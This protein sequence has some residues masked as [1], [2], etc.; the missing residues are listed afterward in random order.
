MRRS[1]SR[2]GVELGL[3]DGDHNEYQRRVRGRQFSAQVPKI[4]E[5]SCQDSLLP[6]VVSLNV[7]RDDTCG[8]TN[9]T[10]YIIINV[11]L[12]IHIH[13]NR[14]TLHGN[15]HVIVRKRAISL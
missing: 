3:T 10:L 2:G 9:G 14:A 5:G 15:R 4:Y 13:V 11:K 1:H 7:G 8:D 12:Q 6:F